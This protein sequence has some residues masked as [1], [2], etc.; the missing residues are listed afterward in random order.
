MQQADGC[1]RDRVVLHE[2]H[3]KLAVGHCFTNC[4]PNMLHPLLSCVCVCVS[5]SLLRR[6]DA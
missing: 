5:L 3:I 6:S 2:M 4:C 1:E